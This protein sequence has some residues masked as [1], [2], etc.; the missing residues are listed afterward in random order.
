LSQRGEISKSRRDRTTQLIDIEE[1]ADMAIMRTRNNKVR[2]INFK[3]TS[4]NNIIKSHQ[5]RKICQ[6]RTKRRE[7]R[8]FQFQEG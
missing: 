6:R 1:A 7:R 3:Q 4:Q 5:I 8:D 2:I